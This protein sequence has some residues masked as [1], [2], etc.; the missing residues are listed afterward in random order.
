MRLSKKVTYALIFTLVILF[1]SIFT[2]IVPCQTAPNIPNPN[3]AW[4]VCDLNP[5]SNTG[6]GIERVYYGATS[7]ITGAYIITVI[8]AFVAAMLMFH[9]TSRK[10]KKN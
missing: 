1:L 10:N 3:Y 9:F 7:S 2:D 8:L 6:F 4:T 5:D